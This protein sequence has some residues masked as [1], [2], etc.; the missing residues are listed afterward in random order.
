MCP[1]LPRLRVPAIPGDIDHGAYKCYV[2]VEPDRLAKGWDRD[3]IQ[4]EIV[5]A[6]VPCFSG[7]CSEVYLEKAFDG[8]GWRPEKP[9]PVARELGETSLM[10]LVHPTLNEQEI[11][12]TCD[13]LER[14]M[15][16]AV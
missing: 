8:T 14:V 10:F 9:M 7:S 12:K 16:R 6:G 5:K 15:K 13:V 2:F 4:N 11:Q 3:R 1:D